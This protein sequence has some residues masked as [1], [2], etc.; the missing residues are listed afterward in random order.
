MD[1]M[2]VWM[3]AASMDVSMDANGCKYGCHASMDGCFKYGL[4]LYLLVGPA[5][6]DG[7]ANMDWC[8]KY[9]GSVFCE[10]HHEL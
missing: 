4:V 2:P 6:M 1:A 9:L 10:K 7:P 8:C 3:G 5:S